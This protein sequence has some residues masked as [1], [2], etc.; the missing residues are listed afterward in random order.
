MTKELDHKFI[1]SLVIRLQNGD[2]EAFTQLY[3]LTYNKVYNYARHYLRDDF[4]AQDAVQEVFIL[5]LKNISTLKDSSL[6]IAWLNQISFHVCFDI[7][8]KNS[9]DYGNIADP[10]LLEFIRDDNEYAN[11]ASHSEHEDEKNRLRK[12]ID[13]LPI[14]EKQ[15]IILRYYNDMKIDEIV[16]TLGYSKSSVKRY[17]ISGRDR[18]AEALKRAE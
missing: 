8:R 10:E 4:L 15:C 11:P 3:G 5:A 14:H 17:L 13:S 12:A 18:L 7:C 1:S 2:N 9:N 6:F 16:D